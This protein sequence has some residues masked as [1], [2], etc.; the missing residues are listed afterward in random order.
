M[1]THMTVRSFVVSFSQGSN[2]GSSYAS[3][4][5][6]LVAVVAA[7]PTKPLPSGSRTSAGTAPAAAVEGVDD[8]DACAAALGRAMGDRK[9]PPP[10]PRVMSPTGVHMSCRWRS[11]TNSA[12]ASESISCGNDVLTMEHNW[13]RW[14]HHRG[15]GVGGKEGWQ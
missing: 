6:I 14:E 13:R 3:G 9:P 12:A 8:D 4:T 5:A 11:T 7:W 10:S 2:R 1:G 15:P